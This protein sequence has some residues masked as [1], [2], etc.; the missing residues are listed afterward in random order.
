MSNQIRF[1]IIGAGSFALGEHWPAIRRHASAVVSAVCRRNQELLARAKDITGAEHAFTDWKELL[2]SDSVDAVVICTP[3]NMHCEQSIEALERGIHVLVEK[4][5]ALSSSDAARMVAAADASDAKFMVGY[6]R[7]CLGAWRSARRMIH[8][9]ALGSVRQVA[10]TSFFDTAF[11]WNSDALPQGA[12]EMLS[13]AG[14]LAPF[15]SDISREGN[16]RSIP[17]RAGGGM[18][19]DIGTH[20]ID[21]MLWLAGSNPH[22][23]SALTQDRGVGID[24]SAVL[25]VRLSNGVLLSYAYC[26]GVNADPSAFFGRTTLTVCGDDGVLIAEEGPLSSG[27]V[28]T[29]IKGR[30]QEV[31]PD[32]ENEGTLNCFI[33]MILDSATNPAPAGECR[34]GGSRH[35]GGLRIRAD[36]GDDSCAMN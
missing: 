1:G 6:N 18:L 24:R 5:M 27:K 15:L 35:R 33:D 3:N 36:G 10:M 31:A 9:G 4:P 17:D 13:N 21:L 11:F 16:W 23:V 12:Q 32:A 22:E 26:D 30:R 7:R 20:Y 2:A 25:H 29:I 8:D 34:G 14:E 19:V 28:E